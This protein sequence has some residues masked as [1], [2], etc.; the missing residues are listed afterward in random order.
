METNVWRGKPITR[1]TLQLPEP[2]HTRLCAYADKVKAKSLGKAV[3]S[4]LSNANKCNHCPMKDDNTFKANRIK[5]LELELEK[6]KQDSTRSAPSINSLNENPDV[7]TSPLEYECHWRAYNPETKQFFCDGKPIDK[8]VCLNR[9][10]RFASMEK[11]CYPKGHT[12]KRKPY[13]PKRQ[14]GWRDP[15]ESDIP[16]GNTGTVYKGSTGDSAITEL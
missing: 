13:R 2:T 3:D 10:G 1:K 5:E 12:F 6:F 8:Y 14:E 9:H 11:R 16:R 7:A 15:F 4:A